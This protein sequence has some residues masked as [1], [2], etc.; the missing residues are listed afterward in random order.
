M[1]CY[2]VIDIVEGRLVGI[3]LRPFPKFVSLFDVLLWGR[4][5]PVRIPGDRC[6]LY[7]NQ[8]RSCPDFL[9][10]KYALSSRD[11][12]LATFFGEL[13]VLDEVARINPQRRDRD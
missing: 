8:P 10:L 12:S 9:A 6:R 3:H 2:G 1:C 11:S 4:F 13:A 5:Y 7:Y